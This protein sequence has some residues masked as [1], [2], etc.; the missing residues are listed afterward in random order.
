MTNFE[1]N[2]QSLRSR[3]GTA[4]SILRIFRLRSRNVSEIR[5]CDEKMI[6]SSLSTMKDGVRDSR[7]SMVF[8]F[9]SKRIRQDAYRITG[10]I[11][12]LRLFTKRR[13]IKR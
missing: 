1:N 4:Q 6:H 10:N 12:I 9:K 5:A 11:N 2:H 7:G 8:S 3:Q 13:Q